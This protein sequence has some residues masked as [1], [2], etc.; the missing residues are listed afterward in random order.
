MS[1]FMALSSTISSEAGAV[2]LTTGF[3]GIA[4]ITDAIAEDGP[5]IRVVC[6]VD[7]SRFGSFVVSN[8]AIRFLAA[9]L[10]F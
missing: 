6:P 3:P 4:G 5:S 10:I 2:L 1:R 9:V 8:K 7:P